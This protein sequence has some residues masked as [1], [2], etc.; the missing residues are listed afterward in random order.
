[1]D[2]TREPILE[3][4]ITPKEGCKLVIRSSKGSGQEEFFVDS[5]EVVSFGSTFFLRSLE[6][7]KSFLVPA[8][9]YEILEVRETRMVLK[10]VGLDHSIKIGRGRE[11]T[12][13]KEPGKTEPKLPVEKEE[14][15]NEEAESREEKEK[16]VSRIEKKK[17]KRRHYRKRRGK[18]EEAGADMKVSEETKEPQEKKTRIPIPIPKPVSQ[19]KAGELEESITS[20][21]TVLHSLLPPPSILLSESIE[22]Y[23]DNALFKDI[24]FTKEEN[25]RSKEEEKETKKQEE[26]GDVEK[27]DRTS[28]PTVLLEEPSSPR[29]EAPIEEEGSTEESSQESTPPFTENEEE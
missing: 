24:F 12:K 15:E 10:N 3:S 11:P 29:A 14:E 9:D 2:F 26:P 22:K 8:S 27:E 1:M 18:E 5:V 6:R 4:V 16:S 17:E 23:K 13:N 25:E 21:P 19:E 28:F 20:S 7:P